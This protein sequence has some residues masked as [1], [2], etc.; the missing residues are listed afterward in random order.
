[1][2]TNPISVIIPLPGGQETTLR[3][4]PT[5]LERHRARAQ[6][7]GLRLEDY[8]ARKVLASGIAIEPSLVGASSAR[9]NE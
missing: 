3:F 9:E 4:L 8:L 5:V 6:S 2:N 7:A 1:M